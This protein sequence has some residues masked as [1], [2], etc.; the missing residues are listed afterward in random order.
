MPRILNAIV[1]PSLIPSPYPESL[2]RNV[3]WMYSD[4]MVPNG[5]RSR[6]CNQ[7][8]DLNVNIVLSGIAT[9]RCKDCERLQSRS[10]QWTLRTCFPFSQCCLFAISKGIRPY[11]LLKSHTK[12]PY[13]LNHR[14][15]AKQ[16]YCAQS[17][18]SIKIPL[19]GQSGSNPHTL[20]LFGM[21]G[22]TANVPNT[23]PSRPNN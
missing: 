10:W 20:T 18:W 22:K 14:P 12:W 16:N 13:T 23:V 9:I 3:V 7:T 8:L 21:F 15:W 2:T 19:M 4:R 1:Y 5:C 6:M 17:L 11:R